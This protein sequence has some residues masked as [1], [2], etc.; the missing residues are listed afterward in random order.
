MS[1]PDY[2]YEDEPPALA[3]TCTD[4]GQEYSADSR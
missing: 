3:L 1:Y 4:C 2:G